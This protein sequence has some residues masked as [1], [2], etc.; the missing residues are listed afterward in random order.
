[1]NKSIVLY[2]SLFLGLL[3]LFGFTL[4][5]Y[6]VHFGGLEPVASGPFI[7]SVPDVKSE[8]IVNIS[9]SNMSDVSTVVR[10]SQLEVPNIVRVWRQG[11]LD[12]H[13]LLPAHNSK[14]ER[15]GTPQKEGKLRLL[16]SKE[17]Q[18][19]DYLTRFYESGLASKYGHEY[20]K[21]LDY[22]ASDIFVDPC[23]IHKSSLCAQNDFCVW[24][25][26]T[27]LC[28]DFDSTI[29]RKGSYKCKDTLSRVRSGQIVHVEHSEEC[30]LIITQPTVIFSIDGESQSMFYH[31]WAT[32]TDIVEYWTVKLKKRRDIHIIVDNVNDPMFF[33]Y[34]GILS[35][36]GWRRRSSQVGPNTCFCDISR[37]NTQQVRLP[38]AK[39]SEQMINFL[40][41]TSIQP[42]SMV[43]KI[44]L[45]S[46]RRKRFI[47]NEY[48]LIE[49]AQDMGY[50]C[51]LLPLESMTLH[52]QL[53]EL[54][55]LDVLVGIH[56]SA[57]D[58][59]VFLHPG[60]VMLQLLPYK[61]EHRVSF[62][63][64]AHEADVVYM[65]WQLDD[66]TKAVFHWDLL[67]ESNLVKYNTYSKEEILQ[68]GQISA[69][70]RETTMFWINQVCN[71]ILH[72]VIIFH[73]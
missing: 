12:W 32:W 2:L 5:F 20:G 69:D 55:S 42:P 15:F 64:T 44:G 61:V 67:K 39:S 66:P 9:A 59:S 37:Y 43:G 49:T 56:G 10:F 6:F 71:S 26:T 36:F 3:L 21:L 45:V 31:W 17:V 8:T 25:S 24:N 50:E 63:Q 28:R 14:W 57:L 41:L 27:S 34:F 38:P 22:S 48:E 46:R 47:L 70:N 65:E 72:F 35:D 7:R 29:D 13:F 51:V 53:K 33:Q 54:R 62:P 40:N 1:M 30:N 23:I 19:T 60:S 16:V 11:L 58:N 73:I 68:A 18:V 4:Q 52:E